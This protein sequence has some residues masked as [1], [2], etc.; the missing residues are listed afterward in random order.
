MPGMP[1]LPD[2]PQ[3]GTELSGALDV[4]CFCADWCGA[5]REYRPGFEAVSQEFPDARFLWFDIEDSAE[6]MGDLDVQ[7]F[8][9]ILIR[10][11]GFVQHY[12]DSTTEYKKW[13]LDA[14]LS[15]I[16][17]HNPAV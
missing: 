8:P 3:A 2:R 12:A 1:S 14:D 7:N 16:G 11:F 13:Q 6:E 9:T 15:R 10:K 5:C 17:R 4:L